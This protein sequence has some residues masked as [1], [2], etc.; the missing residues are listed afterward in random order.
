MKNLLPLVFLLISAIFIV[1]CNESASDKLNIASQLSDKRPDSAYT[2]LRNIDYSSLKTDSLKARYILT[3]A[4][5]NIRVGRSLITDT[6]LNDAATYYISIGDTS[7]WVI[8][9]QLLSGYD[10]IKGDSE[11][12]LRRLEDMVPRIKNPELLWDTYIHLLEVSINSQNYIN[13]YG[14]ADWLLNHTNIP[15]Q[16]LKFASAK[17]TAQY[18]QGNYAEALALY[19]SIISIGVTNKVKPE[20]YR[21]FYRE[22]AET[23]DGSDHSAEAIEVMNRVYHHEESVNDIEN[24]YRQISLS[25]FYANSGNTNKAQELLDSINY[26]ATQPMFEIY[27]Y[28]GML[29]AALQ[30]KES[31]RLPSVLMHNVTRN[32]YRN[33]RFSQFDRQT[34]LESVIELNDDIY[35]LKIQRQQ[36]W[37]LVFGISLFVIVSGIIVYFILQHRKQRLVEAEERAETLKQML[38]DTEKA[39]ERK[40]DSSD[41]DKLKAALLRQL[42]IF[43]TFAGIPTQ[44]SRDA[45]KK[46]STVGKSEVSIESLV[47]WPEFYSMIDNLYNGFHTKL[48]KKY[49][50]LFND[51]EQQ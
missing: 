40:T 48:I 24:I 15:E 36:L 12:A 8:A 7:N 35:K 39:E 46:I 37:L 33:Y 45:L 47:D 21:K 31:G 20:V 1:S 11:S 49:P 51:K 50:D 22:Y 10:F 28:I 34:A 3:K 14:Y 16:I 41:S 25:Q 44:Q 30:F 23:L 27:G 29:K 43:K 42:G 6:L 13:A 38:K 17:S 19:D 18:M 9:S 32:L 4:L 26:D 5:T 2:I